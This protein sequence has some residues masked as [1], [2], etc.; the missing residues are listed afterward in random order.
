MPIGPDVFLNEEIQMS[1][2]QDLKTLQAKVTGDAGFR[3]RF[4]RDPLAAAACLGIALNA[5][6]V[7]AAKDLHQDIAS[8]THEASTTSNVAF[9]I[10]FPRVINSPRV[11]PQLS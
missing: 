7:S 5:T 10:G 6:Q 4:L 11:L 8:P 3:A 2:T 1:S 9:I